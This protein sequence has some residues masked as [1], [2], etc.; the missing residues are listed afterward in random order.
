MYRGDLGEKGKIKSLKKKKKKERNTS[1]ECGS[2]SILST[3]V[4]SC[5]WEAAEVRK[6]YF[7]KVHINNLLSFGEYLMTVCVC[8]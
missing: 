4:V 6:I 3:L 7:F 2:L 1:K 8:V 5:E